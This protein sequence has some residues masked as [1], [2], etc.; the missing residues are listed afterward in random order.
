M[1][2]LPTHRVT[3]FDFF[4]AN[5]YIAPETLRDLESTNVEKVIRA[6]HTVCLDFK[7]ACDT[8]FKEQW[9]RTHPFVSWNE[10]S[11]ISLEEKAENEKARRRMRLSK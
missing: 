2:M 8:I 10:I 1:A 3:H 5:I 9:S 7:V 4:S 11:F 6:R